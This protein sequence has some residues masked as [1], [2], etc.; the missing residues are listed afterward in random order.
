MP[1]DLLLEIG[2]EE[3]PASFVLPA[4]AEMKSSFAQKALGVRL[5]HGEAKT[6]GSPRRL[7]LHVAQVA[8]GQ[9]DLSS[10]VLGPPVRV[11]F[12][13]EGKLSQVGEKWAAAQGARP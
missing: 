4:L 10:E 9:K 6:W 7:A 2:T 12:D 8:D 1:K 13:A 3:L 5:D 11:A